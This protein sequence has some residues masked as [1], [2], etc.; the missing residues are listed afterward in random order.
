MIL[1]SGSGTKRAF[2]E[3]TSAGTLMTGF[4]G[5]G[6]GFLR[7]SGDGDEVFS[8]AALAGAG[9]GSTGFGGIFKRARIGNGAARTS[10]SI[11]KSAPNRTPKWMSSDATSAISSA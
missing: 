5:A 4:A 8:T 6:F 7:C 1:G 11:R 9:G 10:A 3:T 2:G